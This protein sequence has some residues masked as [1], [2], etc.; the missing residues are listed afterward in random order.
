MRWAG[1]AAAVGFG[2]CLWLLPTSL[3]RADAVVHPAGSEVW[4]ARERAVVVWDAAKKT[5]HLVRR[6]TFGG[7][8]KP[9]AWLVATPS[10]PQVAKVDA[11]T[12]ERLRALGPGSPSELPAGGSTGDF[13]L[14][15]IRG[16]PNDVAALT[17]WL[18]SAGMADRPS[19]HGWALGYLARG[20]V[21]TALR[22]A[23]RG[24]GPA[25]RFSFTTDAPFFPYVDAPEDTPLPQHAPGRHPGGAVDLLV[26][27]AGPMDAREAG[28]LAGPRF[29]GETDAQPAVL[30][31]A[32]GAEAAA[33]GF[34]PASRPSW[35]LSRLYDAGTAPR[36]AFDD[37]ALTTHE[38]PPPLDTAITR[39]RRRHGPAAEPP[40]SRRKN[41]RVA[42]FV[43]AALIALAL[44]VALTDRTQ[45]AG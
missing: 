26:I 10:V 45:R 31:T 37:L 19:L 14:D 1:V 12:F 15:T 5:E 28:A 17:S 41:E 13:Q 42:L 22:F 24:D 25:V 43:V 2:S 6:P 39:G 7:D 8:T 11:A 20:W 9:L 29:M 38:P 36:V 4:L 32:L 18:A 3:A 35:T 16:T 30:A 27:A 23:S 33:W 40:S 44:G 21:L 34:D